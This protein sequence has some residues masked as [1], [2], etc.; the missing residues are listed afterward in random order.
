M[1]SSWVI[2]ADN[3]VVRI[4]EQQEDG[5]LRSI[6]EFS[7]P[8]AHA[9]SRELGSDRPGRRVDAFGHRHALGSE[10]GDPKKRALSAQ[11]RDIG[12]YV[13]DAHAAGRFAGLTLVAAPRLLGLLRDA[14]S[15]ACRACVTRVVRK[16]LVHSTEAE[17]RAH[18]A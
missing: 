7:N 5:E 9:R 14:L 16:D 18:L 13:N 1:T 8:V 10:R 6:A 12:R 4:Y 2:V 11:A 3:A 15:P 17:L